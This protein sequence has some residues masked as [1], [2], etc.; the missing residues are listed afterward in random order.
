[1]DY[2]IADTPADNAEDIMR[3]GMGGI[4]EDG[5]SLRERIRK[6]VAE[7]KGK[8]PVGFTSMAFRT[9]DKAPD[10]FL[11]REPLPEDTTFDTEKMAA[12]IE[13][14]LEKFAEKLSQKELDD[15]DNQLHEWW[16]QHKS[17][18]EHDKEALNKI[19]NRMSYQ[20][21][22]A[23]KP[24]ESKGA[25]VSMYVRDVIKAQVK[26]IESWD[27]NY[28]AGS[29]KSNKLRNWMNY[30][31][32]PT[33]DFSRSVAAK[34]AYQA[35]DPVVRMIGNHATHITQARQYATKYQEQ[36]NR[37]PTK[38]ELADHLNVSEVVAGRTLQELK[39]S[40]LTEREIDDDRVFGGQ[41]N[42]RTMD[43]IYTVYK[44]ETKGNQKIMEHFFSDAL[45]TP[46]KFK[47]Q[48]ELAKSL[49]V[50]DATVLR[51]RRKIKKKIDNLRDL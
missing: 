15:L 17:T 14:A 32:F 20:I 36:Y 19:L 34:S 23:M 11:G 7:M 46:K 29:G 21:D 41:M 25:P 43:A 31:V 37:M 9:E 2:T 45:K 38:K 16:H 44:S 33:G 30:N 5:D 13:E 49:G 39:R 27:P 51:R 4:P 47:T 1:M 26:A 12:Y 8:E 6:Q 24:Q 22:I 35:S 48:G 18:P 28:N 40:L 42:T 10:T 3:M 50:S